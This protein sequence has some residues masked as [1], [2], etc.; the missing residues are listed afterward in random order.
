MVNYGN[1]MIY[2]LVCKDTNITDIYVGSTTNFSRRKHQHKNICNDENDKRYNVYVYEFIRN[3]G[4]YENWDMI[5]IQNVNVNTKRE[6]EQIER[7]YIDKLYPT[8]NSRTSYVTEDEKKEQK[9][10][11]CKKYWIEKKEKV[12]ERKREKIKCEFCNSEVT[13]YCLTRHQKTMKCKKF[14]FIED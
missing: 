6:L 13:K 1:S 4:G 11:Y 10:E 5:L 2:K 12:K 14:Q 8:L 3:N 9:K 7:E